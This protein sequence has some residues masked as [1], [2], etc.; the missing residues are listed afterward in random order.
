[1][2]GI[3]CITV[4]KLLA[5]SCKIK[6]LH[7]FVSSFIFSSLLFILNFITKANDINTIAKIVAIIVFTHIPPLQQMLFIYSADYS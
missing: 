4:N 7:S 5:G 2:V 6:F 1:M 3:K